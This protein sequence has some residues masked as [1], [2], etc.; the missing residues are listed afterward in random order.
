[1]C[2]KRAALGV[3]HLPVTCS[4]DLSLLRV[5]DRWGR[6]WRVC[7]V[8][9]QGAG[10]LSRA[11]ERVFLG[12][13]GGRAELWQMTVALASIVLA[14][15]GNGGHPGPASGTLAVNRRAIVSPS[16]SGPVKWET[17]GCMT[18]SPVIG[19][20]LTSIATTSRLQLWS[21]WLWRARASTTT[22]CGQWHNLS[23]S[24]C[25]TYVLVRKG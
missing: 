2:Y 9:Q 4:P 25:L 18:E 12:L 5:A 17:Y 22:V 6:W 14:L 21:A 1:M 24:M 10:G 16:A 15:R 13:P 3:S 8:P 11:P 20:C 19:L 7:W 23:W